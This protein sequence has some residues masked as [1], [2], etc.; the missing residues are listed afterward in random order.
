M[1]SKLLKPPGAAPCS[2]GNSKYYNSRG[3]SHSC[4]E[5]TRGAL[6]VDA[7][8][9]A[10][11]QGRIQKLRPTFCLLSRISPLA[12]IFH[13]PLCTH[14]TWHALQLQLSM[15]AKRP[16]RFLHS[17]VGKRAA[18]AA[19][20]TVCS[21]QYHKSFLWKDEW[22]TRHA[23]TGVQR[24]EYTVVAQDYSSLLFLCV[25]LYWIMDLAV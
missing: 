7:I 11:A 23:V 5:E 2:R 6:I 19:E 9:P 15:I 1:M 3:R 12:C 22:H 18:A 13:P 10:R 25:Q 21:S 14:E 8:T 24:N 17:I 4:T 16:Y 20:I